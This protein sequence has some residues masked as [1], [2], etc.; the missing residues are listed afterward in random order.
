M[1]LIEEV[2]VQL[3]HRNEST[4][5]RRGSKLWSAIPRRNSER[6]RASANADRDS[7]APPTVPGRKSEPVQPAPDRN[8][9]PART[10][11]DQNG[12]ETEGGMSGGE[13]ANP[14]E[15]GSEQ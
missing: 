8:S 14:P 10:T 1:T 2:R 3:R 15:Q 11:S 13:S 7:D 12:E 4:P 6:S 5:V 9:E